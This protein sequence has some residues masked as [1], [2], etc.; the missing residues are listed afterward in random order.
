VISIRTN[1]FEVKQK[2]E[3]KMHNG[4]LAKTY[5]VSPTLTQRM[6]S[7]TRC[8]VSAKQMFCTW[9]KTSLHCGF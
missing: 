1:V 8:Y 2:S 5:Q 7:K 3:I 6:S 9:M 4:E